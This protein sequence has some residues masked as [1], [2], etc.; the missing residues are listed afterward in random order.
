MKCKVCGDNIERM[1]VQMGGCHRHCFEEEIEV[2]KISQACDPNGTHYFEK[3]LENVI[4][5]LECTATDE[6]DGLCIEK[7]TMA[8]GKFLNLPEF[9]GF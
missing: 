3:D 8:H 9:E 1:N 2:F 7:V 6:D 4:C 5:A